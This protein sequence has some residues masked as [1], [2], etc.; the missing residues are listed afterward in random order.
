L[1]VSRFR[2]FALALALSAVS[3]AAE[4][5]AERG[6]RQ[7][8]QSCGF[9]HGEDA[10]GNR[11]PDLVRSPLVNHDVKGDLIG[12]VIRN[13][14]PD[15][16]MPALPL[17][18]SAVADI[19][20]FLHE[21][22]KAALHSAHVSNDYPLARLLSG[23]AAAGKAYF[24]GAGK[25]RSCH[26]PTDDLAGVAVRFTPLELEV[27]FLYPRGKPRTAVVITSSGQKV[28]GKLAHLDEFE[29]ALVGPEGWYHSWARDQVHLVVHDP[30]ARHRELLRQYSD[31]D[32]HNLFAYLETLK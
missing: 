28:E 16:G 8:Q 15:K 23:S 1:I 9:C 14:R 19:V 20:A 30:L 22:T 25:C 12:P 4:T 11:A 2:L 17:S 18:E 31:A 13:G 27:R 3:F 21:R 32:I 26:S 24:E 29:V 5:P 6:R 10:T 7:F